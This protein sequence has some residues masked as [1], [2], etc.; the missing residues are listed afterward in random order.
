[1][2]GDE[3]LKIEVVRYNPEVDTAPHSASLWKCLMTQLPHYWMRWATS[4]TT[5]TGP[6]LPLVLPYGDLWFLRHDG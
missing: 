1:M 4:K 5:G 2:A 6:E 3:N